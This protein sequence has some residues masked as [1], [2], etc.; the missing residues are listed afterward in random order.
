MLVLSYLFT[1]TVTHLFMAALPYYSAYVFDRV[2]L[3]AVFMAAFLVPA[4]VASPLW[5]RANKRGLTKQK[6]LLIS[7]SMF[8]IG[9][10]GLAAGSILGLAASVAIV[11]MMGVAFAGLQLFAFSMVPDVARAASADGSTAAAYT[12]VWT[13]TEATGTAIGPYVYSMVLAIG[14]FAASSGGQTVTQS[15]SAMTALVVGFT[16]V[17]AI[18]MVV[19]MAFQRRYR[20]QP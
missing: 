1:G 11:L 18:L 17:P 6:G 2:G 7:Q 19:A 20:L 15:S 12:G 5:L 4:L 3:T 8:V 13:A 14:G 9:S 16:A 10:L